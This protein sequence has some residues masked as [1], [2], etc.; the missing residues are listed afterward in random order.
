MGGI[1]MILSSTIT[2]RLSFSIR[3]V[4]AFHTRLESEAFDEGLDRRIWSLSEQ[5]LQWDVDIARKRRERPFEVES[6][7]HEILQENPYDTKSTTMIQE[8]PNELTQEGMF[9]TPCSA[10]ML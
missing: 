6:L 8:F 3:R 1:S 5:C 4:F 2:V 10:I 7:M 9:G